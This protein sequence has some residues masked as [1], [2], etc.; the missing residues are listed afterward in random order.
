MSA[1]KEQ[2]EEESKLRNGRNGELR[3]LLGNVNVHDVG[4]NG[5]CQQ[6]PVTPV[7]KQIK[8]NNTL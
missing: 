6:G 2:H 1:T 5:E 8:G 7:I 3:K 4:H